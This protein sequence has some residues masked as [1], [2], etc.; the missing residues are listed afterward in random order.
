[1]TNQ[2]FEFE[3]EIMFEKHEPYYRE[4]W[5]RYFVIAKNHDEARKIVDKQHGEDVS[6]TYSV[7]KTD[8]NP[9]TKYRE[10]RIIHY[11]FLVSNDDDERNDDKIVES[12]LTQLQ[13]WKD[14]VKENKEYNIKHNLNKYVEKEE[15]I[16]E[17][18]IDPLANIVEKATKSLEKA[19][20]KKDS[21]I[22]M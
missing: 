10:P 4:E 11:S 15:H 13:G 12:N 19:S 20:K 17:K 8:R 6:C 3:L 5:H 18:Y 1:M 16:D 14:V 22:I 2:L 7:N 9:T 21:C